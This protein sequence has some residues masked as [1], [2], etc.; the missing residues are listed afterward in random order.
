MEKEGFDSEQISAQNAGEALE[1]DQPVMESPLIAKIMKQFGSPLMDIQIT[2]AVEQ[3]YSPLKNTQIARAMEQLRSPLIDT[4]IM[5]AAEQ[6]Y[7]PLKNTQIMRAAE[8]LYS[9]LKN[10]QIERA[11]EQ[12]RSPLK[13]TQI[14]RAVAQL[15]SPLMNTQLQKLFSYFDTGSILASASVE[16]LLEELEGRS[17]DFTDEMGFDVEHAPQRIDA[18]GHATVSVI[19][20]GD[21][22]VEKAE[23][24]DLPG[25]TQDLSAIPTWFLWLVLNLLLTSLCQWEQIRTSVVDLNAR[26]PQTESFYEIRNFIR[27]ELSGKPGDIRL[28]KGSKVNLREDPSMKAAVILKLPEN[29]PV[30]VRGK[31][32]RTWLWVSYEHEGYWIDGY[33]STKHLK[34]ARKD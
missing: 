25:K 31:E 16:S 12:L 6:L 20:V 32:D 4:Q 2:R 15:T 18:E 34:K 33:I 13:D 10:T 29:T 23:P 7:S 8:Q 24:R 3:L 14:A 5:R 17:T 27:K 30:V 1:Q 21:A 19:A 26:L 22:R 11:M 9:P 28:V